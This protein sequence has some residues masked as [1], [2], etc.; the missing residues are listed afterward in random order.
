MQLPS[1]LHRLTH[2][3][4][5]PLL[6]LGF[7]IA[8][9]VAVQPDT[10][11]GFELG[12]AATTAATW[13]IG[14]VIGTWVGSWV[15]RAAEAALNDRHHRHNL[16]VSSVIARMDRLEADELP[17]RRPPPKP[18]GRLPAILA[19]AVA[20]AYPVVACAT[21]AAVLTGSNLNAVGL[22]PPL[23]LYLLTAVCLV[24]TA[25]AVPARITLLAVLDA[26]TE[27][28]ANFA[29]ELLDDQESR[30]ASAP[31]D[32]SVNPKA[33]RQD[34]ADRQAI[35]SQAARAA[36]QTLNAITR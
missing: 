22:T 16:V 4:G 14:I 32:Q 11:T 36:H 20:R 15:T 34:L 17:A 1:I 27:R 24:A 30:L 12:Q 33:L 2:P 8:T 21:T 28:L 10:G 29:E 23:Q 19:T 31:L 7:C 26:D 18:L 13:F 35:G 5:R 3:P 9:F 25:A 6:G